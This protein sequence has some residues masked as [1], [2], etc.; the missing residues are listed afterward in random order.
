MY[1]DRKAGLAHDPEHAFKLPKL[2]LECRESSTH[3]TLPGIN[4]L[5]KHVQITRL[6][7]PSPVFGD[8]QHRTLP[9]P[10]N[11]GIQEDRFWNK[12]QFLNGR[13]RINGAKTCLVRCIDSRGVTGASQASAKSEK[14]FGD[15]KPAPKGESDTRW[16]RVVKPGM[17]LIE[18]AKLVESSSR[19]EKGMKKGKSRAERII[20]LNGDYQLKLAKILESNR[21]VYTS[22][23]NWPLSQ[24]SEDVADTCQMKLLIDEIPQKSL[25]STMRSAKKT[26][27]MLEMIHDIKAGRSLQHKLKPD[28]INELQNASS[29][30]L[31]VVCDVWLNEQNCA[32]N[33]DNQSSSSDSVP[34]ASRQCGHC[35]SSK[36]PEWRRGPKGKRSLCN[37]CGLFYKKLVTKFGVEQAALILSQRK[38][39]SVLDRRVPKML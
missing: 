31:G 15:R 16:G 17:Q 29:K 2:R 6:D 8:N 36:T 9:E 27:Q 24:H 23:Q 19:N 34:D 28:A 26:F 37:A 13:R 3:R 30:D 7:R 35:S 1:H 18:A 20:K 12:G 4:E 39:H 11:F 22:I 38:R 33:G 25:E 10:N 14:F 5:I 32:S 21:L